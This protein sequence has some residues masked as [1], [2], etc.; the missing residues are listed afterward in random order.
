MKTLNVAVSVLK[1][2]IV[3]GRTHS[4]DFVERS[5]ARSEDKSKYIC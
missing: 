2:L 1:I 5:S 4:F 3:L